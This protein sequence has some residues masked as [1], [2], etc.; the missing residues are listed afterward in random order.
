MMKITKMIDNIPLF[1]LFLLIIKKEIKIILSIELVRLY[2]IEELLFRI[3]P[4]LFINK[5]IKNCFILGIFHGVYQS[6]YLDFDF[7]KFLF[8]FISG[9]IYTIKY[10]EYTIIQIRYFLLSIL[11]NN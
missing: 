7:S 5:N 4:F 3:I 2:V 8:Y 11:L 1:L 6:I 9:F 10:K